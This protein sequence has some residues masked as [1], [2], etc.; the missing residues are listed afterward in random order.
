M[1]FWDSSAIIPLCLEEPSSK[2]VMD[3][4]K[5]DEDL[6]VW[7]ATR[8]ECISAMARRRRD[9]GLTPQVERGA[10]VALSALATEWSEVQPTDSVRNRAVRLLMVHALRAADALQLA[11]ALIWTE[12]DTSGAEFVCLDQT[13]RAAAQLE[14]F[15]VLP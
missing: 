4:A 11:A 5:K 8:V 13:L 2:Q 15:V 1:K 9:G 7:W 14:G 12:E 10:G 3:L 6:I